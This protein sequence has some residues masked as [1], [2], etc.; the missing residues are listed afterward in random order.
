MALDDFKDKVTKVFKDEKTSDDILDKAANAA[1]KATGGKVD[2]KI[3]KVRD[4]IDKKV[5][6]E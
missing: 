5:G 3:D 1:K 6:D 4:A 2:D